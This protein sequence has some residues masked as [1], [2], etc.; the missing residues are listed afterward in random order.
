[1][2]RVLRA[3]FDA[4]RLR[5]PQCHRGAVFASP[6]KIRTQCPVCDLVFE[7]A[8][9]EMTGGM[10]INL[11]VTELIVVVVGSVYAL[12]TTVPLLPL[13]TTLIIFAIVFPILFY[14][15]ARSL[16]VAILYLTKANTETD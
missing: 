12:F 6:F 14:H 8:S 4:L 1:M 16:W 7:R 11:V 5:C 3:L 15:P 9:G 13:L 10:V 2:S